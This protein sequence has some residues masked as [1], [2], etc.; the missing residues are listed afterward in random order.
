M[1]MRMAKEQGTGSW[2]KRASYYAWANAPHASHGR[3]K[4]EQEPGAWGA[5]DPLPPQVQC[6]GANGTWATR[7]THP[8]ETIN[9]KLSTGIIGGH[10]CVCPRLKRVISEE[11]RRKEERFASGGQGDTLD[12]FTGTLMMMIAIIVHSLE[13]PKRFRHGI[14]RHR[15]S[16]GARLHRCARRARLPAP[17]SAAC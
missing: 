2:G 9:D 12:L 16:V 15:Q 8:A 6:G 11:R 4:A 5:G 14:Q 3:E 17:G 7:G 13:T 10:H 1:R